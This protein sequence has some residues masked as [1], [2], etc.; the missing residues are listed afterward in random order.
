MYTYIH[1]KFPLKQYHDF[2]LERR[3]FSWQAKRLHS[4]ANAITS[5]ILMLVS[6]TR[7]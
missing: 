3:T 7:I 4:P 2:D 6:R 1:S 5:H